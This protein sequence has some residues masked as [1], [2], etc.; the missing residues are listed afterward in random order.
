[1]KKKYN[2]SK[3]IFKVYS[4]LQKRNSKLFS[5]KTSQAQY[6]TSKPLNKD[7]PFNITISNESNSNKRNKKKLK[8]NY[9]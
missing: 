8:N 4:T 7:N 3:D 2:T 6:Q 1:M 5:Y 9:Y